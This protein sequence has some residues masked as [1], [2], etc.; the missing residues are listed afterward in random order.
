MNSVIKPSDKHS[1]I[2]LEELEP[3]RLFSGG[4]EGLVPN[5]AEY[6]TGPIFRDLD[7]NKSLD[8][9]DNETTA[10]A[11]QRSREIVFIDAS[12]ENYQQFVDDVKNNTDDN[13]NI[14][15]VVLDRDKSGIEQISSFLQDQQNV[16]AVHIISHG[17]DGS[18]QLGDTT[19]NADSLQKNST[20][21][22]LWANAFTDSGDILF[23]GC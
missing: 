11:E 18:V 8:E 1:R 9:A 15:V 6:L 10:Q 23:Y 13:R 20:Q 14:E 3:R 22:A 2:I 16:D 12:I 19:L 5:G 7:V 17:S 4:I 21:I